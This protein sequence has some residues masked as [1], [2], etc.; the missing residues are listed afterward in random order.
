MKFITKN[1][2]Y[3][4]VIATALTLAFRFALSAMLT[5][6][7]DIYFVPAIL[8]SLSMT[9]AG[10]YIGR[11]DGHDLPLYDVGFRFHFVTYVQYF[12]VTGIWFLLGYNAEVEKWENKLI[13]ALVWGFFL[14]I[15]FVFYL[16]SRKRTIDGLKKEDLFD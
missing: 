8:Y 12:A 11:K 2:A 3:F 16:I 1:L 4:A 7:S 15:H 10:W 14:V 13:T 9:A 5:K 6:E